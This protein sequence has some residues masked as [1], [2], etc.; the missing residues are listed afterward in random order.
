MEKAYLLEM[1][2]K[3]HPTDNFIKVAFFISFITSSINTKLKQKIV[4]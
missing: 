1:C 2:I 3:I 4:D